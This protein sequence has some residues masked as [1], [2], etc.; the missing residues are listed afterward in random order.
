MKTND[1]IK[2]LLADI[3]DLYGVKPKM[4]RGRGRTYQILMARHLTVY[5]LRFSPERRTLKFIGRTINR[6]HSTVRNSLKVVAGM[7]EVDKVFIKKTED[8]LR[9]YGLTI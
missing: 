1:D 5:M 6:D 7:L 2:L 4:L 9:K 8:I 3:S